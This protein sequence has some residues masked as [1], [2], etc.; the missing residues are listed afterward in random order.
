MLCCQDESPLGSWG[1]ARLGRASREP[2]AGAVLVAEDM[3][4]AGWL[5]SA[6]RHISPGAQV[7]VMI[8]FADRK[9]EAPPGQAAAPQQAEEHKRSDSR[10]VS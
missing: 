5:L 8:P 4:L 2:R 10:S 3:A 1:R 7:L 6:Q 9:A